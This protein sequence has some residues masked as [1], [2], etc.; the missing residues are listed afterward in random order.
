MAEFLISKSWGLEAKA[1]IIRQMSQIKE[2]DF[3]SFLANCMV[4]DMENLICSYVNVIK[5][6]SNQGL[7]P[8]Q[9]DVL[10]E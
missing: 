4:V 9:A 7:L 5:N 3:C 1:T 8:S 2:S 10:S 6:E